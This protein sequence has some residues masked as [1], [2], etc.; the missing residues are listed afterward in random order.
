MSFSL[1]FMPIF[2]SNSL[3]PDPAEKGDSAAVPITTEEV[4]IGRITD[5]EAGRI[6]TP[7]AADSLAVA[8]AVIQIH[9]G[10]RRCRNSMV[11]VAFNLAK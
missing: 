1:F 7:V 2:H 8:A 6:T 3:T 4:S 9:S 10:S 11:K 5:L